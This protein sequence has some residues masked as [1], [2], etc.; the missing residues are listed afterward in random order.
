MEEYLGIIKMFGGNFAP[1]GWAFCNGQLMAISQYT[2]LF[3]ILGTTYGGDGRTTFAL[4]DLRSRVPVG[5][6]MGAGPGLPTITLGEVS[7]EANH[8]LIASEM[9][10]HTHLSAASSGNASQAAATSGATIATPGA[11][12][13]RTFTPTLGFNTATPDVTLN[14]SSVGLAGGSQ[15]HNNMQPYLGVSYIICLEGVF[16][17]RN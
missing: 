16:P 13:G 4:P 7:G 9:P 17:S 12:S 3:S 1:R 15:P 8:T 11:L 14:P 6:G 5:G 2:A 10:A